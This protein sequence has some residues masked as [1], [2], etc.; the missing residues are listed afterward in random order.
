MF[1][2][3]KTSQKKFLKYCLLVVPTIKLKNNKLTKGPDNFDTLLPEP[4]V[5]VN[6]MHKI[7]N[8]TENVTITQKPAAEI[9]ATN[10]P[11]QTDTF[12]NHLQTSLLLN[13]N[14]DIERK[15]DSTSIGPIDNIDNRA[16]K[17][18]VKK[19]KIEVTTF[20]ADCVKSGKAAKTGN[21]QS[22]TNWLFDQMSPRGD[23]TMDLATVHI[24]VRMD[25]RQ[26]EKACN[27]DDESNSSNTTMRTLHEMMHRPI[28]ITPEIQ[29]MQF[30]YRMGH[31]MGSLE[32][33]H[34]GCH[35]ILQQ[36]QQSGLHCT[37]PD[38]TSSSLHNRIQKSSLSLSLPLARLLS[39]FATS[40]YCQLLRLLLLFALIE[41]SNDGNIIRST[42]SKRRKVEFSDLGL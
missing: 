32:V 3:H 16:Q 28:S 2:Q 1:S 36:Q 7:S 39:R 29:Q 22:A 8:N 42:P 34:I 21:E 41:E 10:Q 27:G 20:F 12:Y 40:S 6:I 24:R 17:K 26:K 31:Q 5:P 14:K 19:K 38:I 18:K 33:F 9:S 23:D 13:K 11:Q 4:P 15:N 35:Y 25:K 30:V 37:V